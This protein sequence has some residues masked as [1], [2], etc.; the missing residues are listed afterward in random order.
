M[1]RKWKIWSV[2]LTG[3]QLLFF[4]DP[5][6]ALSLTSPLDFNIP[7]YA[8]FRP[9]EIYTVKDAI[10]LL[11]TSYTKVCRIVP[12]SWHRLTR[13]QYPHTFRLVLHNG[14]QMLLQCS[15]EEDLHQWL[16]RINYASAFRT[17][18]V[19]IRPSALSG[20]T[21]HLTG[22][23]AATSHMHDIYH[24]TPLSRSETWDSEV[25]GHLMGMLSPTSSLS[26]RPTLKRKV[27][28]SL[29]LNAVDLDSMDPN[30]HESEEFKKTFHC[31]KADLADTITD[32]VDESVTPR[33][34]NLPAAAMS[35]PCLLPSRSAAV[36]TRGDIIQRKIDEFDTKIAHIQAE[37]SAETRYLRNIGILAPFKRATRSKL[38][39]CVPP[40]AKKISSLRI[41]LERFICYRTVLHRDLLSEGETLQQSRK[42]AL[43]AAK[44]TLR[45]RYAIPTM[46]ISDVDDPDA[47][48]DSV[49]FPETS[50]I[51]TP[52][53][54]GSSK[55]GSFHSA[56]DS[57]FDWPSSDEPL[58]RS[59]F[60]Q[61]RDSSRTSSSVTGPSSPASR[62]DSFGEL[63]VMSVERQ[64][65]TAD[66]E[67]EA[68]Q[69]DKT[70]AAKR[71][72]LI[73]VPS[74]LAVT[75]RIRGLNG[76]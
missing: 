42:V 49:E 72:S 16:L 75:S 14:R 60:E 28:M 48:R 2:I 8:E 17:A 39:T 18:G 47:L 68:E 57:G 73:K 24:R 56:T 5:A 6:W 29:P 20:E 67:E 46:T 65:G 33:E 10:A 53:G 63:P 23:A 40:R 54:P 35:Q 52:G 74:A 15:D 30:L 1:N 44:E 26:A 34:G 76:S 21:A 58:A 71:V 37:L 38:Q 51:S 64:D 9:D 43:H 3:S 69:W 32:D 19:K 41:E 55:S 13:R 11:D 59:T 25:P 22:V 7:G 36:P 27:T 70:R 4:R 45:K 31:V 66:N 61:V 62:A 50:C 12:F